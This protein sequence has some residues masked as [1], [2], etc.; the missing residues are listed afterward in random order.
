MWRPKQNNTSKQF[1]Q[2]P[3]NVP[4][5]AGLNKCLFN[6]QPAKRASEEEDR[7]VAVVIQQLRELV[8]HH[9]NDASKPHVAMD[10]I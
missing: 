9:F 1:Y 10:I 8:G 6:D 3:V 4:S 5:M 7:I 2:S